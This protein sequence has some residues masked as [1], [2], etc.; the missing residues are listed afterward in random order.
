MNLARGIAHIPGLF[1]SQGA[2]HASVPLGALAASARQNPEAAEIRRRP[3]TTVV[4]NVYY[5][6]FL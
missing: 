4:M 1:I 2:T 6:L 5:R 3:H